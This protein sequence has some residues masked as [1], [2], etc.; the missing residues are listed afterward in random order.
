MS[1]SPHVREF[2]LNI[3]RSAYA[4]LSGNDKIVDE[5]QRT[6]INNL[7]RCATI[8]LAEYDGYAAELAMATT[9]V[10]I[11]RYQHALKLDRSPL[12]IIATSCYLVRR[13]SPQSP[14]NNHQVQHVEEIEK[15]HQSI[16]DELERWIRDELEH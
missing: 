13:V 1:S 14:L 11:S 15:N 6:Y 10:D 12:A 9:A 3:Q 4:L 2:L 7:D 5:K 8:L 16:I